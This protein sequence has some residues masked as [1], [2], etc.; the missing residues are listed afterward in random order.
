MHQRGR[1]AI[2]GGQI[3]G[4]IFHILILENIFHILSPIYVFI[5]GRWREE[6]KKDLCLS[7]GSIK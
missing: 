4:N 2:K 7:G 1:G 3:L 5:K 6:K